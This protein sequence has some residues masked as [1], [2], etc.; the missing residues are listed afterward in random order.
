MKCR[1]YN[2]HLKAFVDGE[3][4]GLLQWRV[5][6]HVHL[7]TVCRNECHEMKVLSQRLQSIEI[8]PV[9][10]GLRERVLQTVETKPQPVMLIYR[11]KVQVW[12]WAY[13]VPLVLMLITIYAVYRNNYSLQPEL[14]ERS[15]VPANMIAEQP[16]PERKFSK[17]AM[18][19]DKEASK[20][21]ASDPFLPGSSERAPGM[22]ETQRSALPSTA[23]E[24]KVSVRPKQE[25]S[26]TNKPNALS[27]TSRMGLVQEVALQV[28]V[29]DLNQALR[30]T[31]RVAE[32]HSAV[33]KVAG[34]DLKEKANSYAEIELQIPQGK[35]DAF[36]IQ[37]RDIG[38]VTSEKVRYDTGTPSTL[39]FQNDTQIQPEA[40]T[41]APPPGI[42][43]ADKLAADTGGSGNDSKV[44]AR[45][46]P[47]AH[48]QNL[49][50]EKTKEEQASPTGRPRSNLQQK[51][52]EK[53][54]ESKR[55]LPLSVVKIRLILQKEKGG[56]RE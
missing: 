51:R 13:A 45:A 36:V 24:E 46:M 38:K 18:E 27:M 25:V 20:I 6:R 40:G 4:H 2:D 17:S 52:D 15:S 26:L 50:M 39:N 23:D 54:I 44:T 48:Q 11:R 29:Q 56:S 16:E 5:S 21:I 53:K 55:S 49:G 34:Y 35:L 19:Q 33:L 28:E 1:N 43:Q 42:E 47:D 9:P 41:L 3:L 10:E 31:M 14:Q 12:R 37:L 22:I 7:C 32:T 8:P 30:S